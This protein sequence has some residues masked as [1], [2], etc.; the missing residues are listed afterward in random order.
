MKAIV[1]AVSILQITDMHIMPAPGE[2]F[3]GIDPE[4][5]FRAVLEQAFAENKAIDLILITGDLV[6]EPSLPAYQR[7]LATLETYHT[8]CLCLAGNHDDSRLMQ[9]ILNANDIRCDPQTFFN[10]WQILCLNSQ[11][12]GSPGGHL[13]S[14]ELA[15]L[16]ESL[17][18]NPTH[19]TLI[20]V[21]HHCLKIDSDWM[22]TMIIDNSQDFLSIV[23]Q[24]PQVK[25]ITC[26]HIHQA[27]DGRFESVRILSAPST[28]I[29]FTPASREFSIDDTAPGYRMIDLYADGS[30]ATTVSYLKPTG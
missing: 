20:A 3:Y 1:P 13:S 16:E 23:V 17:R 25:A 26:G 21:H 18:E 22:D 9:Q 8:P 10:D 12:P 15:F 27:V 29:Q 30:I 2:K 19:P 14:R 28:C 6:Q 7:I 11:I 5:T 24:Y 4:W